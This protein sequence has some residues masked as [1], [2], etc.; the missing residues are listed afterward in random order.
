VIH[1]G[2][3]IR[4]GYQSALAL[5][6]QKP[7]PTAILVINDLL[8][9]GALR[10]IKERGLRIPEDISIAGFDDIDMSGYLI[11]S[12]TTLHVNA[13]DIGRVAVRLILERIADPEKPAEHVFL[14]AQLVVR[15]STGPVPTFQQEPSTLV[16]PISQDDFTS[17]ER[18]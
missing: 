16:I 5:L 4:D 14:P 17:S 15:E 6:D 11:P 8:S 1:T 7:R 2:P 10:A 13:E 18:R 9:I 3:G 12:L